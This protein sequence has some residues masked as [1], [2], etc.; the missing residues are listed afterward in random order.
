[1]NIR[2]WVRRTMPSDDSDEENVKMLL[3]KYNNLGLT[4][5]VPLAS[6][7]FTPGLFPH[8]YPNFDRTGEEDQVASLDI[9]D[10]GS[11]VSGIVEEDGAEVGP[12]T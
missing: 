9:L 6:K 12:T 2:E 7:V 3:D 8:A 4:V 11:G 10:G 1:M 5:L